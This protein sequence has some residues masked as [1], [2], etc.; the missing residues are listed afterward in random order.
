MGFIFVVVLGYF[1]EQVKNRDTTNE[2]VWG[3]GAPK[4]R[5]QKSPKPANSNFKLQSQQGFSKDQLKELPGK[6]SE[7]QTPPSSK[8]VSK[9]MIT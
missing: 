9:T 7:N 5:S 6:S 4:K 1:Y 2:A 8:T 3:L